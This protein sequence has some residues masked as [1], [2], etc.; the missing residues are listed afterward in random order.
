MLVWTAALACCSCSLSARFFF[1]FHG[2]AMQFQSLKGFSLGHQLINATVA[3]T[4]DGGIGSIRINRK[5]KAT[6]RSHHGNIQIIFHWDFN[7]LLRSCVCVFF[8]LLLFSC[9]IQNNV[10]PNGEENVT[11][12]ILEMMHVDRHTIGHYRCTADNRVGQPDSRDIFVNVLCKYQFIIWGVF[13]KFSLPD[14]DW[15]FL[16]VFCHKNPNKYDII[17]CETFCVSFYCYY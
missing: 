1:V 3:V 16:T 15:I 9:V 13:A 17:D 4:G 8:S 11:N 12:S 5:R 10:M 2:I 14:W 7:S 6:N